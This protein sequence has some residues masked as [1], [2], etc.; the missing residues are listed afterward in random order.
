MEKFS[1]LLMTK[2]KKKK[3]CYERT[4]GNQDKAMHS[5]PK[6]ETFQCLLTLTTRHIEIAVLII[7]LANIEISLPKS[8]F[9]F[10]LLVKFSVLPTYS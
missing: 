7:W 8:D 3:I 1:K 2:K 5:T 9:K 10:Q 6:E 4:V